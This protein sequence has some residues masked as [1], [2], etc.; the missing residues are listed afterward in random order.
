MAAPR[1]RTPR[2]AITTSPSSASVFSEPALAPELDPHGS[3]FVPDPCFLRDRAT[4]LMLAAHAIGADRAA[5]AQPSH[6][7]PEPDRRRLPALLHLGALTSG[8]SL[9]ATGAVR[10]MRTC[11]SICTPARSD[12]GA[13]ATSPQEG[14][15]RALGSRARQWRWRRGSGPTPGCAPTR[16]RA[17]PA[18]ARSGYAEA[19]AN[20]RDPRRARPIA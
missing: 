11:G 16:C 2:V 15:T 4:P 5:R 14:A 18:T 20:A 3:G 1:S 13:G 19:A 7:R 12:C 17:A 6:S 8:D 10:T 9:A